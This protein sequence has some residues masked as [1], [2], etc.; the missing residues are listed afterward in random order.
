MEITLVLD[1]FKQIPENSVGNALTQKNLMSYEI[2][3][4]LLS[5]RKITF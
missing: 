2:F 3:M 4:T 5:K 1:V